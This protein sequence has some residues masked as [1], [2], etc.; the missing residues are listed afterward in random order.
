M[1]MVLYDFL[2]DNVVV[3]I[4][5]NEEV[6]VD[7]RLVL[8]LCRELLNS[9]YALLRRREHHARSVTSRQT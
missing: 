8:S 9:V 5:Y 3:Y 4:L 2:V 6:Y 1:T 7:F